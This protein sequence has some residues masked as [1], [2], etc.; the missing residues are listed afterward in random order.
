MLQHQIQIETLKLLVQIAWANKHLSS[1]EANYILDLARQVEAKD[2]ELHYLRNTLAD[3]GHLPAP[4]LE[5]LRGHYADVMQSIDQLIHID[6]L[7]VDDERAVR[8]AIALAL[9]DS[10]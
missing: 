9:A 7:I 4:N 2:E 5:L 8:D 6:N 1:K 3:A 10:Y